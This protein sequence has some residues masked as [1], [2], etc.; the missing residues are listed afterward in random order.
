MN[1]GRFDVTMVLT[2]SLAV[3]GMSFV[4][5]AIGLADASTTDNSVPEYQL[6]EEPLNLA[7]DFPRAPGTPSSGTLYLNTSRVTYSNNQVWLD[8]DTS[9]G[10]EVLL[11]APVS[12][13]DTAEII[14]NEWNSGSVQANTTYNITAEGDRFTLDNHSYKMNF[15]VTTFDEGNFSDGYYYEVEY[16][17]KNQPVTDGGFIKRIPIVGGIVSTGEVLAAVVGWI[18]SIIWWF[19]ATSIDIISVAVAILF[20]TVTFAV[21]LLSWLITTYG[22]VVSS[23]GAAWVSLFL[24]L[25]G[26]IL[27]LE[28]GKLAMIGVSLLPTT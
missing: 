3:I 12:E 6:D 5:P 24:A 27:S 19:A 4:F 16:Q 28:M 22:S 9:G 11:F 2:M 20:D 25:P 7:G 15:E 21:S 23:A 14:V 18:G 8:G 17:A 26:I 13:N 1:F 10:T